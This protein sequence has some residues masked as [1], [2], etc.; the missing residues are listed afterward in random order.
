M[1]MTIRWGLAAGLAAALALFGTA[2]AQSATG[3]STDRTTTGRGDTA[4]P[5]PAAASDQGST[6]SSTDRMGGAPGTSS[7]TGSSAD[8]TGRTPSGSKMSEGMPGQK[9]DKGLQEKLE[10]INA[11]NDAEVHLAELATKNAQSPDVKQFAEQM[12]TA[13]Q[14]LGQKLTQAAQSAGVS[15]LE[16]K[17][18]QKEH[19]RAMKDNE[20][21]QSKT[22]QDFDKEFM[23]RIV[24][25]HE[26]SVKETESAA[27][28]ARKANQTELASFLE[29]AS[30]G[31]KG[32]LDHA[33]QLRASVGRGGGEQMRQGRRPSG[34]TGSS[35]MGE[36]GSGRGDTGGPT[37][38]GAS[39]T[40]GGTQPSTEPSGGAA[41]SSSDQ[42]SGTK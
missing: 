13:H 35:G 17:T 41:G 6:G 7:D 40:T 15:S 2:Q 26:K 18:Y 28:D 19:D 14:G 9:I 25:D 3:G 32:H 10:K 39:G 27:K 8:T 5:P 12:Q 37:P 4:G 22:G 11:A 38:G 23:S 33:K 20:K 36:T 30:S 31:M 21:L 1:K 24:K 16:G 42:G 34:P 29:K